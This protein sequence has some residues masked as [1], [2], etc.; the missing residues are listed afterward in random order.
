MLQIFV[1]TEIAEINEKILLRSH[2]SGISWY[3]GDTEGI[4]CGRKAK[5]VRKEKRLK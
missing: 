5:N 2:I 4:C 3:N 1:S